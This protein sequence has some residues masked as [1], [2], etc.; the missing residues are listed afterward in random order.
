MTAK[1]LRETKG[2]ETV[3]IV[4]NFPA[5]KRKEVIA[6]HTY[7]EK[8]TREMTTLRTQRPTVDLNKKLGLH[9]VRIQMKE[10]MK[11]RL[12]QGG[13]QLHLVKTS[14]DKQITI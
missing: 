7:K 13:L 2:Y 1:S 4:I 12:S 11:G 14:L 8:K 10:S 3:K 6:A 9:K 5:R